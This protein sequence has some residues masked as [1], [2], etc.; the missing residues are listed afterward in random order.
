MKHIH[1]EMRPAGHINFEDDGDTAYIW[2]ETAWCP[3]ITISRYD[4]G[5]C[6]FYVFIKTI[7]L[8]LEHNCQKT[9]EIKVALTAAISD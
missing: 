2:A 7:A 4:M 6:D 3:A 9:D 5:K 1:R 8:M